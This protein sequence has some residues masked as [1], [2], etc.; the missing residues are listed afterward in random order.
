MLNSWSKMAG[1]RQSISR[2]SKGN[3]KD[4][5]QKLDEIVQALARRALHAHLV[6]LGVNGIDSQ[7]TLRKSLIVMSQSLH[8]NLFNETRTG[9]NVRSSSFQNHQAVMLIN[10]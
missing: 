7:P 9:K 6:K 3:N 8:M 2:Q 1:S 10:Y 4:K 5:K